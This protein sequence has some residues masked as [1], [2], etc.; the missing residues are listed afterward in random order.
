MIDTKR[1][2]FYGNHVI[3]P[4]FH[5]EFFTQSR[6]IEPENTMAAKS[7]NMLSLPKNVKI[8]L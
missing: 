4:L 2:K 3:F 6:Y 5:H 1:P 7:T 8:A